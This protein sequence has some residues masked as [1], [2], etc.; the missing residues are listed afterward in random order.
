MKKFTV[1]EDTEVVLNGKKYLLEAGDKIVI[2]EVREWSEL[3]SEE[4]GDKVVSIMKSSSSSNNDGPALMYVAYLD[5]P[6][7]HHLADIDLYEF[8]DYSMAGYGHVWNVSHST[9]NGMWRYGFPIYVDVDE[10]EDPKSALQKA[11]TRLRDA[12]DRIDTAELVEFDSSDVS[13]LD[14]P[15]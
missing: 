10:G 12:A 8:N 15:D 1:T 9:E 4:R 6:A 3:H 11:L 13:D 14:L 2:N 7:D 5:I